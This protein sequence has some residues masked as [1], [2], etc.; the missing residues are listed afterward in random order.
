[1]QGHEDLCQK[2]AS[3]HVY[4]FVAGQ[5]CFLNYVKSFPNAYFVMFHT[6]AIK[7]YLLTNFLLTNLFMLILNLNL[8]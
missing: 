8:G 3:F 1:M 5:L 4:Q 7:K 2:V 6:F